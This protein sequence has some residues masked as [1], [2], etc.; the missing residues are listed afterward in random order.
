MAIN[1]NAGIVGGLFSPLQY[2]QYNG[3]R[4]SFASTEVTFLGGTGQDQIVVAFLKLDYAIKHTRQMP[5]GTAIT[6]IGKTRGNVDFTAKC[7]MLLAEF[8]R[9]IT[10]LGSID[11]TGNNSYGSTFFNVTVTYSEKGSDIITDQIQGCTIDEVTST[12]AFGPEAIA[13]EFD[14]APLNILRNTNNG[15]GQPMDNLLIQPPLPT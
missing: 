5:H 15:G 11:P 9:M 14:L 8:N 1:F 6:P 10:A 7:T 3:F 2:P 13:V 4:F 12:L